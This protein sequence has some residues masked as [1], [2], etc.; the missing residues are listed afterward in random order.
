MWRPGLINAAIWIAAMWPFLLILGLN[1]FL[2][3]FDQYNDM[4][5]NQ[6][7]SLWSALAFVVVLALYG[8]VLLRCADRSV[9][10]FANPS[11]LTEENA[12]PIRDF[13]MGWGRW[14]AIGVIGSG[15]LASHFYV[16]AAVAN[17]PI[18]SWTAPLR[19]WKFGALVGG[20]VSMTLYLWTASPAL[21]REGLALEKRWTGAYPSVAA[22]LAILVLG[23]FC[24]SP[25]NLKWA[26]QAFVHHSALI[27]HVLFL[28]L[29]L[30]IAAIRTLA[31]MYKVPLAPAVIGI[32]LIGVLVGVI[33]SRF[34]PSLDNRAVD[35]LDPTPRV[36]PKWPA[37]DKPIVIFV[38]EGGGI[39]A[40]Y[41]ASVVLAMMESEIPGAYSDIYATSTVSG[42]SVGTALF[43]AVCDQ[44]PK[45][46]LAATQ[47]AG[48]KDFLMPVLLRLTFSEPLGVVVPSPNFDRGRALEYSLQNASESIGNSDLL[49]KG[50]GAID[51]SKHPYFC[52]NTTSA[53]SGQ[54]FVL[55]PIHIRQAN[56]LRLLAGK[57]E[58]QDVTLQS[59]A[60][61]SARFP[62]FPGGGR[63]QMGPKQF[64]R[65]LD[66]GMYDNSG[67]MTAFDIRRTLLMEGM[68]SN[69]QGVK[70]K[71]VFIVVG[72]NFARLHPDQIRSKYAADAP[73]A[74]LLAYP[75]GAARTLFAKNTE[76]AQDLRNL[77]NWIDN[78]V[79][80]INFVWN[81]EAV[82]APLGWVLTERRRRAIAWML[83]CKT[84]ARDDVNQGIESLAD[85][86]PPSDW[87]LPKNWKW[88]RVGNLENA[89][90]QT[91][92]ESARQVRDHNR[93]ELQRLADLLG[94]Q[95]L[96][97]PEPLPR[98]TPSVEP[99]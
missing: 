45:D 28:L 6:C 61:L 54:R 41:R 66:G 89:A 83:G 93:R 95:L 25:A 63:L 56:C 58:A 22:I 16:L 99:P 17:D 8:F 55:A 39:H 44:K 9:E 34:V 37:S 62:I 13:M 19:F 60:T 18:Q 65:L 49:K 75:L 11:W 31:A 64:E 21:L 50:L 70:R 91:P 52:F 77:E 24:S 84:F 29:V 79:E 36:P 90:E 73:F 7:S 74:A 14:L 3:K 27:S 80:V 86:N 10:L 15:L 5:R 30:A 40:L 76:A 78:D 85:D 71:V 59:A 87:I 51:Y 53:V 82:K 43:A 35:Y 69:A 46:I 48:G 33:L 97:G 38:A 32:T 12:K 98:M 67:L 92:L 1:I 96:G 20:A 68:G 23:L 81:G 47:R 88:N 26:A 42:G 72:N 57:D 94:R 2:A 4:V